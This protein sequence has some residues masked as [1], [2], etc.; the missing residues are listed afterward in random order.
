ML[1]SHGLT[2][3]AVTVAGVLGLALGTAAC[4]DGD[5]G[6]E[7][8][9]DSPE[10]APFADYQG[11]SG[12]TVR[13][14]TPITDVEA[15][16]YEA[17]WDDFEACTGITISYEGTDQFE[18]QLRVRV[19]GGNPPDLA[20]IPQPG[21]IAEMAEA[22]A[23][24][25]AP[26]EVEALVSEN[27]SEGWADFSTVGEEF[28]GAPLDASL[29]SLV[30][31]SPSFFAENGYEIPQTW[32]E[33]LTLSDTIAATGTKPWC[34]GIESDAATGW[35]A[36]DWI[37]D[38]MLRLHGQDV[39]NQ[40]INHEIPFNDPQVVEAFDTVGEILKNDDYVNGGLG[41]VS[42]IATTS[43]QDGG[44]SILQGECAL[45]RQA[46][47]Y[48]AQWPKGT[49]VGEDGD[50]YAFYL[51][52]IDPAGPRPVLGAAGFVVAFADRPE[53]RA[54]QTY[55]ATSD[56]ADS[57]AVQ[58]PWASANQG[59]DVEVYQDP[60]QRLT[61]ETLRDP[62]AVLSFDASDLMPGEVGQGSFWR[63]VTEWITGQSTRETVDNIEDSW[64]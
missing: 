44:L 31:Y 38:V 1:V 17:S 11:N 10:C 45:H 18:E 53:V 37:E 58:G 9:P 57:R 61:A 49:R 27:W 4:G 50:V 8:D 19:Q 35:P 25:P 22:D 46:S 20:F 26:A 15:D 51:P 48:A 41:D 23:A 3:R 12:T 56:W 64:P 55:L 24:V 14:Y 54:V 47:F 36:T 30:W 29:K 34:A 39:Y 28:Y 33:L 13:I 2:R 43:Y 21:L 62:D 5:D 59:V 60:I 7:R 52:V 40:W 42:S 63:E 32:D 6:P 16:A